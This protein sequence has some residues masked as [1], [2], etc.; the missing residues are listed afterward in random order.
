MREQLDS[1]DKQVLIERCLRLGIKV[2]TVPPV[3]QWMA[4]QINPRQVQRLRIED[5]LERKP[6]VIDNRQVS[7]DLR[8]KRI[9]V[10]GAA[11][12]IGSEIVRQVMAFG[13]GQVILCDQ[14]ESALH[15]VQLEL[16]GQYAPELFVPYMADICNT[17]RM[18]ALFAA[19]RPE[20]IYHAAAYK[21][22]PMME[23]HPAEA[24]LTNVGGTRL[25]ADM[26][27]AHGVEKFVMISTDKAVN[28]TNVMGASKRIAEIYTQ[29]LNSKAPG[30]TRF[31][32][33]RFGNV[34]GSNGS[35]IPHFRKQIENGGPVTVTHPDITRYFMSI[36]EAVQ[37]GLE[38]GTMGRGGEI[39]VFDM[40]KP[41][42]IADLAK[43]MV[44]LAGLKPG[45]DIDIVYTGLRPGEKLYEELLADAE[46]VL[47]T[48]HA[49]ISIA[50]VR[51]YG[52]AQ[53]CSQISELLAAA[54]QQ[55]AGAIVCQMKT[56][57][58]EFK[59]N[60][61]PYEQYDK[62]PKTRALVPH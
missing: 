40:G 18:E 19:Y 37:R 4:G 50:Q 21:H 42:K 2:M 53:V 41:V 26:A 54:R 59:S 30:S 9:L 43:K 7:A 8:G 32:T 14:A 31:I 34:L 51:T 47:P 48:H 35:V 33:T 12:S 56:I 25:L 5:L 15:E 57:V 46:T 16:A 10:T 11:G 3:Q 45:V 58:P 55:E 23:V 13:P 1:R 61:S 49:K 38:A 62:Q 36:P 27:V 52:L 6:I 29:T 22:V 17:A 28:P 20:V 60:N 24:V 39:F 44:L